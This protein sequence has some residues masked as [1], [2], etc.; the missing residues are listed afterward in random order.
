MPVDP[1]T[2]SRMKEK[3]QRDPEIETSLLP[4]GHVVLV[5]HKTDWA[6]TL[7]PTGALVWEFC[8]GTNSV[9]EIVTRIRGIKEVPENPALKEDIA[10]L[11]AELD[12]AGFFVE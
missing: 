10:T 12:D 1:P 8:D 3:P 11:I 5:S 9:D 7:T 2:Q 6:H 4:D